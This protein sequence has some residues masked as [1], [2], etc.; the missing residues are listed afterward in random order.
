MKNSLRT[1]GKY[2]ADQN[3]NQSNQQNPSRGQQS[4]PRREDQGNTQQTQGTQGNQGESFRDN[5]M[6]G[7]GSTD[8][9][10]STREPASVADDRG[11]GGDRQ[12]RDVSSNREGDRESD[13]LGSETD[14]DSNLS[15]DDEDM[16]GGTGRS[17]R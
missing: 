12:R 6:E 9:G 7:T 8:R 1:E 15:E 13:Q 17:N 4:S 11:P 10:R 2:M 16:G 5:D 3:R 14:I